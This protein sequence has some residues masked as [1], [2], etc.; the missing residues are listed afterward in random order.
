MASGGRGLSRRPQ[1]TPPAVPGAGDVAGSGEADD[2]ACEDAGGGN[3]NCLTGEGG[4]NDR[5]VAITLRQVDVPV[6]PAP[7]SLL[8]LGLGLLGA[9]VVPM[10]RN[11]RSA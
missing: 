2:G 4:A 1:A 9:G 3:V 6:V 8:L 7:A 10:I 11:R 5:F